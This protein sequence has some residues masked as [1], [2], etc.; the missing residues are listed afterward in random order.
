MNSRTDWSPLSCWARRSS[1]TSLSVPRGGVC[2]A[3][4]P[5]VGAED[6]KGGRSRR[7]CLSRVRAYCGREPHGA[8]QPCRAAPTRLGALQGL[9]RLEGRLP[10]PGA[11]SV[12]CGRLRRFRGRIP[13]SWESD[14]AEIAPKVPGPARRAAK[15]GSES[16]ADSLPGGRSRTPLETRALPGSALVCTKRSVRLSLDL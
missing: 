5:H 14:S 12:P 16:P 15:T 10:G 9:P 13:V 8:G 2:Q 4:S 3:G 6:S 1:E 7:T 11:G